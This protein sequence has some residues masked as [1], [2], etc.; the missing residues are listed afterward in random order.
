MVQ[1]LFFKISAI[2]FAQVEICGGERDRAFFFEVV[3][4]VIVS[5]QSRE[6][7]LAIQIHTTVPDMTQPKMFV[8]EVDQ[9]QC[10]PGLTRTTGTLNNALVDVAKI[11]LNG[12]FG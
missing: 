6:R 3:Q 10:R 1:F 7:V 2:G 4:R 11:R 8:V 9:R 5:R 12:L